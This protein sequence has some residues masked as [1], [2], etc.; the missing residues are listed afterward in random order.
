MITL[1]LVLLAGMLIAWHFP[2]PPWAKLLTDKI[3]ELFN[4]LRN[5][6]Q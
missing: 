6:V 1:G 4:K 2:Q 5:R 3:I